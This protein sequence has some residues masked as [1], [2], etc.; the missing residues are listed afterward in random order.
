MLGSR[1]D[2]AYAVSKISQFSTNPNASHWTAVKRVFRYLAGTLNRGLYYGIKEDERRGAGFTDADWGASEDRKSISGYTFVLN[3]AAVSWNSKK[4]STI[5][6][7]STEAE[8]IALT[9][10][11]TESLWLQAILD[12]L[13]ARKHGSEMRN[14]YIDNQGAIALALNP[15]Y[16]ARTKHIDIQYHFIREHVQNGS[17]Q[18]TYCPTGDMTADIFTKALPQPAFTKHNLGLGLTDQSIL[19]LVNQEHDSLS[20]ETNE[21]QQVVSTGE[22]RYWE[23]PGLTPWSPEIIPA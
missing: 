16:H 21:E 10:A 4:Q 19:A 14:I 20:E 5:A 8:Y 2:I 7:S 18:L 22:G 15:E 13:G 23:S 12:D 6:L 17:I 3:G 9:Q 11:V 1:P